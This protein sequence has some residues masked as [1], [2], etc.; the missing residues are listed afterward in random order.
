MGHKGK[1]YEMQVSETYSQE[2]DKKTFSLITE[3]IVE[4]AH[5]SDANRH[6][7]LNR[8][9]SETRAWGLKRAGGFPLWQ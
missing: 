5:E 3:V 8:G 4:P 6:D 2:Q 9:H 1:G 7:S